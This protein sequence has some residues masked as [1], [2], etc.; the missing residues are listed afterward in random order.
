MSDVFASVMPKPSH[1]QGRTDEGASGGHE[2]SLQC[3]P[4][5]SM[6]SGSFGTA[7]HSGFPGSSEPTQA[8]SL[9]AAVTEAFVKRSAGLGIFEH[10]PE[11]PSSY[12]STKLL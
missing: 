7:W 11:L 5:S 10:A 9:A 4:L 12:K 3:W 6:G 8:L 2:D 1:P